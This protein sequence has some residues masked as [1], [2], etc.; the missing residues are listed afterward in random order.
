[1]T[2]AIDPTQLEVVYNALAGISDSM[3]VML[4]RTSR[5]SIVRLG[6]D[7]STGLLNPGGE[8]VGQ[9]LCQPIHMGGMPPAL[10]AC[11]A[12]YEGRIHPG[13]VFINNDP[14]EGGSHLPDVFM[15]K[16]V[17]A[18]DRIIAFACAM[19]HQTDMGGR[20]AGSNASDSTEIYQEGLRIPPLKIYA[21]GKPNETL[22]RMIEKAVRVP[23]KVL[24]DLQGQVTALRL[25]E[26]ELVRLAERH[27]VEE[28]LALEDALLDHTE[29]LTRLRIRAMPDGRWTFTDHVDDDGFTSE[30]I[31]IV[32]TLTKRDDEIF[33]DF[34]GTSPQVK[35]AINPPFDSTKAMVYAVVRTVLGGDIPNTGGY[36]RPVHVTAPPGTFTNP[37]PPAPVAARYLGCLR[38]SQSV[39]GAFAQMLPDVVPACPGGCDGNI[40]MAG[41][42]RDGLARR[43]WVQVE[44]ANEIASGASA[45]RDG[46]DAQSSPISNITNIP[47][48]LIEVEHPIKVEEYALIPDSEGAG[49]FRGGV[50]LLRH[51]RFLGDETL[52]QLRSDRMKH[53]PYGLHGGQASAPSAVTFVDGATGATRAMPSKFIVTARPGDGLRIAMPG[54]GGWGDPLD[55]DPERVLDDVIEEKISRERAEQ[56][57][58]VVL[59]RRGGTIELDA[60]ATARLRASRRKGGGDPLRF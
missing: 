32:T 40:T 31:E 20:V 42:H 19:S 52:V 7:F 26:H 23:D 46:M 16:P 38:V 24:G 22:F 33:V 56:M 48:E 51:Y 60:E 39:F 1:M 13:D 54:G 53:P 57:Y 50:G 27:G 34:S 4:V 9:G 47:S 18:G 30:S 10:A 28:L 21:E 3:A 12:R 17:F 43:A 5:S 11:L 44:G 2:M 14:Y 45:G 36:F 41:Y 58:G 6:Y 55:R 8:L 25:G 15:F 49:K 35:G 29:R 59:R 37:R